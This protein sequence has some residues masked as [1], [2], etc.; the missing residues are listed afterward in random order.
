MNDKSLKIEINGE[1]G[2]DALP[3]EA[4]RFQA[5][6]HDLVKELKEKCNWNGTATFAIGGEVFSLTEPVHAQG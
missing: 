4:T 5:R 1:L 3:S 2:A 6:F